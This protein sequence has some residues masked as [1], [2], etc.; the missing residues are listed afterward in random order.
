[1]TDSD[2]GNATSVLLY[3]YQHTYTLDS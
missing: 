2:H 1:M 3:A